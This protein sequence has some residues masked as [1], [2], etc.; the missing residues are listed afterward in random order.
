MPGKLRR[1]VSRERA[2]APAYRDAVDALE[3]FTVEIPTQRDARGSALPAVRWR[4]SGWRAD[5]LAA[6]F[7]LVP[8]LWT[9]ARLWHHVHTRVLGRN[10]GDH[11]LFEWM[12]GYGARL[13]THGG[14]PFL[15][16]RLG[17][18]DG[19]N[20][21]ATTAAALLA[22]AGWWFCGPPP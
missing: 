8:A 18:P 12:L 17:V 19:V 7:C 4:L 13:V 1:V 20:L 6:F 2:G 5:L 11:T 16:D 15:T 3:T 21:A 9:T 14:N 10:P 22:L